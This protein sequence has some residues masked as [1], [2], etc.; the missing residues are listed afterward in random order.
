[1]SWPWSS[2]PPSDEPLTPARE[3]IS[4]DPYAPSPN[5]DFGTAFDDD[6]P[7]T[8]PRPSTDSFDFYSPQS[9][10]FSSPSFPT[11]FEPPAPPSSQSPSLDF[12]TMRQIDPAL[13][14]P[15]SSIRSRS[16][17]PTVDYVFADD[18]KSFRKKSGTEQL[19][20]LAGSAY[21]TGALIGGSR[22]CYQGLAASVGK[23]PKLRLN[24]VLN[25]TGKQGALLANA[26]GVLALAF[27]LSESAIYNYS[28]DETMGN[29]A[30]AGATAGALYKSTRGGRVAAIWAVGGAALALGTV[31]ASRRGYY[32]HGLQGIL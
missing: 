21:L 3:T 6:L 25:A 31:Y 4:E 5:S 30:L 11:S 32:G 20:Y 14:S 18:Y 26:F 2:P 1:M 23:P 9:D 15:G 22:G 24:A 19:T 7:S 29:Y 8:S 27:S 16:T 13:I 10:A 17:A 28:S 12:R